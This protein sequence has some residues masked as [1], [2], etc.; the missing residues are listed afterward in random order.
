MTTNLVEDWLTGDQRQHARLRLI[1]RREGTINFP[2]EQ[3]LGGD[4]IPLDG[5]PKRWG[6]VIPL[7]GT[8][9]VTTSATT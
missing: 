1:E 2:R 4:I 9:R 8:T 7:D 6:D 5:L 3:L